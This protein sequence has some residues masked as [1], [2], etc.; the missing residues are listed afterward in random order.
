MYSGTVVQKSLKSQNVYKYKNNN[1]RSRREEP[2]IHLKDDT[3]SCPWANALKS[4]MCHYIA[5]IF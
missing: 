1:D 2:D 5:L 4:T 3:D